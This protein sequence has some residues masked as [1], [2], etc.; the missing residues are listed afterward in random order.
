MLG[1]RI[2]GEGVD[3]CIMENPG[4]PCVAESKGMPDPTD[5]RYVSKIVPVNDIESTYLKLANLI[6]GNELASKYLAGLRGECKPADSIN[7]PSTKDIEHFTTVQ[8]NLNK[9]KKEGLAC[10]SLKHDV[11]KGKDITINNKIMYITKYDISVREWVGTIQQQ[12]IPYKKVMR[13][14]EQAIPNF[15]MVLQKFYQGSEVQLIHL[16]LHTGNI[17]VK[18]DPFEFGMADFGHCV[19]RQHGKDPSVTFYGEY[20]NNNIAKFV[21]YDG[22]FTQLPFEACLLN[23]CYRKNG[24]DSVDP[25]TFIQA[26]KTDPDVVQFSQISTDAIYANKDFLIDILVKKRLFIAMIQNLQ[27]MTRKLKRNLGNHQKVYQ[28][29]SLT[30][31]ETIYFIIT[32]YHAISPFNTLSQEIMNVYQANE[33][34]NLKK[35]ILKSIQAPYD[36]SWS[37]LSNSFKSIVDADLRILWSDIVSGKTS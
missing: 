35:F 23:F 32:R 5:T 29:L 20:L 3:G 1:G 7:P 31:K 10:E 12:R 21:F 2:L 37:S 22:H 26:W 18:Q 9:W 13:D 17:F 6:L 36:N 34:T 33:M 30:E 27:S 4:W 19:F 11:S 15:L 14:I 28:S 25:N 8:T 24:M 16:D